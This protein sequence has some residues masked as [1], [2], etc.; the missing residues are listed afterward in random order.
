M[1]PDSSG[2]ATFTCLYVLINRVKLLT[3]KRTFKASFFSR[4]QRE[5]E[6]LAEVQFVIDS[7]HLVSQSN[8]LNSSNKD[9]N[10]FILAGFIRD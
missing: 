5:S 6:S 4:K 9:C 7:C 8:S 1:R 3:E 10:W 2:L